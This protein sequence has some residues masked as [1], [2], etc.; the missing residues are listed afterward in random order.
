[1]P[2]YNPKTVEP[3]WQDHWLKNKTFKA[4][5]DPSRPKFY[6]LDMVPYPSANGL[7]VGNP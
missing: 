5:I 6:A 3:K 1:M 4:V 7:H 2:R